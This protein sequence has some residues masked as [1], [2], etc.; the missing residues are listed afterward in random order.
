MS[1]LRTYSSQECSAGDKGEYLE[2]I[3]QLTPYVILMALTKFIFPQLV[4]YEQSIAVPQGNE[5]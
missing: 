5:G 3:E 1:L 2:L 4:S